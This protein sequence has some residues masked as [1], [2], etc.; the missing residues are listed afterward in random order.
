MAVT[1]A[2]ISRSRDMKKPEPNRNSGRK[3]LQN[4]GK[5]TD[6][7][8]LNARENGNAR[9][10]P[11]TKKRKSRRNRPK[12]ASTKVNRMAGHPRNNHST[13]LIMVPVGRS[14]RRYFLT[15]EGNITASTKR[16]VDAPVLLKRWTS[17]GAT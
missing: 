7:N 11:A 14:A 5:L 13:K 17:F 3:L 4:A 10:A 6:G 1:Q 9:K 2:S 8:P 16:R 15:F 12:V